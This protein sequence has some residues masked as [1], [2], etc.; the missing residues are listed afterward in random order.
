VPNLRSVI[1]GS[2]AYSDH[3]DSEYGNPPQVPSSSLG[4]DFT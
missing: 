1:T 4:S 3:D 2:S